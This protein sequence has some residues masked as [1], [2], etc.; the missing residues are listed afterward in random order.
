MIT[1][2]EQ[3]SDW[4]AAIDYAYYHCGRTCNKPLRMMDL[5][6]LK[7]EFDAWYHE[8]GW[9][10]HLLYYGWSGADGNS[11]YYHYDPWDQYCWEYTI[12]EYHV[13]VGVY[14]TRRA[15]ACDTV[16]VEI[17]HLQIIH[18]LINCKVRELHP[19]AR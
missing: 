7:A 6:E 14:D 4:F 17:A 15:V 1:H 10:Y 2:E 8:Y 16:R 11:E 19:N 3:N 12:R 5:E 9:E 18:C 13:P